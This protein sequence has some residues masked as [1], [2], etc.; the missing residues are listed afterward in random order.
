MQVFHLLLGAEGAR[1]RRNRLCLVQERAC[2]DWSW[3]EL[4]VEEEQHVLVGEEK[5]EDFALVAGGEV[6]VLD[7]TLQ[8]VVVL[9]GGAL[10]QVAVEVVCAGEGD[11]L[12]P[13]DV[14]PGLLDAVQEQLL[15]LVAARV[16]VCLLV[17]QLTARL[18]L[19]L[20]LHLHQPVVLEE[21]V[22]LLAEQI[23]LLEQQVVLNL[24]LGHLT[25]RLVF[26]SSVVGFLWAHY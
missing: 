25:V 24:Q 19:V 21:R 3:E 16:V 1:T 14:S 26:R 22:L 18:P 6:L 12:A 23:V 10:V 15:Q 2:R 5:L 20:Q 9:F 4:L 7:R 11:G 17:L 8:A 13:L